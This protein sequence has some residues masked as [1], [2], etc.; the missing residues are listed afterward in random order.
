MCTV[1]LRLQILGGLPFFAGL[2]AQELQEINKLFREQ[3][4]APG[5]PVYFAGDQAT[6]MFVVAAGKVK[7][8][9]H[10]LSG[11]DVLLDILTMGEFFGSLSTLPDDE[12]P[13]TAV[14]QTEVCALTI[15]KEDFRTILGHYPR[16]TVKVLDITAER[17]QAAHEMMRQL[18]A[19]SAER[20]IAH[21]LLK[22]GDKLGQAQDV[23]LLI[24]VPLSRDDLAEMTGTTPETASRVISQFQKDGLIQTGRQWV[25]ITGREELEALIQDH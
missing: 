2:S 23:G 19:Y 7:L 12:Y 13:D 5:Q 16:V 21:T 18:S 14:A 1:D 15:G 10:T 11:K 25:A 8:I 3:G 22:L 20:R 9:R 4:Y 24:Q 6:R 17:L